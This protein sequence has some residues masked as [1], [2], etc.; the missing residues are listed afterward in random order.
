MKY[1][2]KNTNKYFLENNNLKE[3]GSFGKAGK[4]GTKGKTGAVGDAG[5]PGNKIKSDDLGIIGILGDDGDIGPR[6]LKGPMGPIGDQGDF[7][8]PA[9]PQGMPGFQGD[10][11]PDGEKGDKGQKGESG[12]VGPKGMKGLPGIGKSG[13]QGDHGDTQGPKG[14]QGNPGFRGELGDQGEKGEKGPKGP[15]GEKGKP[16]KVGVGMISLMNLPPCANANSDGE[17]T[18]GKG[19][20]FKGVKFN[21]CKPIDEY[22]NKYPAYL[23]ASAKDGLYKECQGKEKCTYQIPADQ[24]GNCANSN[25][26]I[27][28]ICDGKED[29]LITAEPDSNFTLNLKCPDNYIPTFMNSSSEKCDKIIDSPDKC[30][31][32]YNSLLPSISSNQ[33]SSG[34]YKKATDLEATKITGITDADIAKAKNISLLAGIRPGGCS[35]SHPSSCDPFVGN[36]WYPGL[37]HY[38]DGKWAGLSWFGTG[39]GTSVEELNKPNIGSARRITNVDGYLDNGRDNNI[40]C[41]GFDPNTEET[42]KKACD[43]DP[44]C[45]GYTL[46]KV[47]SKGRDCRLVD[48]DYIYPNCKSNGSNSC[49]Y[50]WN[51]TNS[52]QKKEKFIRWEMVNVTMQKIIVGVV[53]G[54]MEVVLDIIHVI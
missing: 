33:E 15:K 36:W 22:P 26:K 31:S 45:K 44:K 41:G 7:A 27:E 12:M 11:G 10:K 43:E 35:K 28:F 54:E 40:K 23:Y 4:P 2:F 50:H 48:F 13:P 6:G 39:K 52:N 1:R 47:N 21:D 46:K 19:I 20:E 18:E 3:Y 5:P 16:G 38:P 32:V 51:G 24:R 53:Y 25:M 34:S 9:G 30:K 37:Y 8:C 49:M 14:F 42:I 17:C 29:N